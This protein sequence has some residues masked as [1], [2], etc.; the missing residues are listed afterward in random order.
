MSRIQT[1]HVTHINES[2]HAWNIVFQRLAAQ[3]SMSHVTNIDESCHTYKWVMSRMK[4]RLSEART[5]SFRITTHHPKILNGFT[6]R[7]C[8]NYLTKT[9]LRCEPLKHDV[10]CVTWLIYM[11]DMTRSYVWHDSWTGL[12]CVAHHTCDVTWA[13]NIWLHMWNL[14]KVRFDVI[15]VLW[16]RN[17]GKNET[18]SHMAHHTCD[19]THL[20]VW[21][22]PWMDDCICGI[23]IGHFWG[24]RGLLNTDCRGNETHSH[25]VHHTCDVTHLHVWYESWIYDCICGILI[26]HCWGD[27]GLLNTDCRGNEIHSHVT[28]SHVWRDSFTCVTWLIHMCDVTHSYVWRDSFTR[29]TW[30][31]HTCDV[32]HSHVWRDSFT[33]VTWLIHMCDV[34][35]SHVW[36]DSFTCVTWAMHMSLHTWNKCGSFLR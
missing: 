8:R 36:R 14:F 23:L 2:S 6:R 11:C 15:G 20:H 25:M 26:C 12:R 3:V 7:V 5:T 4:R 17:V 28:H 33:R 10:S 30:L 27:R 22:E 16:S 32:T 29:V 21:C 24:D 35:H 31:I 19:V 1:S 18:H 9:G 34:T 13:M